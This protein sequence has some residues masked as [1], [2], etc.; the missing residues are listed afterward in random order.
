MTFTFSGMGSGFMPP[1]TIPDMENIFS[2]VMFPVFSALFMPSQLSG[3]LIR[4]DILII[5]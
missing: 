5:M 4:S 2:I 1:D 3:F